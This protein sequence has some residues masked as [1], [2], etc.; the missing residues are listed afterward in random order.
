MCHVR[1]GGVNNS[2]EKEGEVSVP[3]SP[4]LSLSLYR[5]QTLKSRVE[6]AVDQKNSV[7]ILLIKQ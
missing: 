2:M 3:L 7:G 1:V 6:E 4:S 5:K